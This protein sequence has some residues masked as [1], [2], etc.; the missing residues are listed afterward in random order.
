MLDCDPRQ[1]DR[2]TETARQPDSQ[3]DGERARE[4]ER[5][6]EGERR[7]SEREREK[8]KVLDKTSNAKGVSALLHRSNTV[9]QASG[10]MLGHHLRLAV[11]AC[12]QLV[13]NSAMLLVQLLG[14]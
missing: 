2:E 13:P 11:I 10:V 7:E 6:S 12:R 3:R 14:D 5:D 1:R 9:N 4:R 8:E